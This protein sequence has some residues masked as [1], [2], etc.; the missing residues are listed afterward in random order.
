[1]PEPITKDQMDAQC[2]AFSLNMETL[3]TNG[4]ITRD[5]Y[6]REIRGLDITYERVLKDELPMTGEWIYW[7]QL[8][9]KLTNG[10]V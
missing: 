4:E 1:M 7:A 8:A 10:C 3:L 6:E 9:C 2:E 5:S